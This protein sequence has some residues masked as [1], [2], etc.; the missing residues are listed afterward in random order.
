MLRLARPPRTS[1]PVPPDGE[2]EESPQDWAITTLFHSAEEDSLAAVLEVV[3]MAFV[4]GR[5]GYRHAFAAVRE[6]FPQLA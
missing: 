2:Y 3:C 1:V 5:D 4:Y 6:Q